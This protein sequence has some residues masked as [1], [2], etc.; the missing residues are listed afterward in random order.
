MDETG[1]TTDDLTFFGDRL[2]VGGND[3]PVTTLGITCISVTDPVDT[4]A[5]LEPFLAHA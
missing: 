4:V 1:R 5:K 2:D 3:Y